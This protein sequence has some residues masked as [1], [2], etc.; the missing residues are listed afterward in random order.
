MPVSERWRTRPFNIGVRLVVKA[1]R[2]LSSACA[3]DSVV[4]IVTTMATNLVRIA[5]TMIMTRLLM[6]EV[7]GLAGIINTIFFVVTM[8]TDLGFQAYIVRHPEGEG[9]HFLRVIWTIH[10]VRGGALAVVGAALAVPASHLL[11]KTELAL[12]LAIA[13]TIFLINGLASLSLITAL[14]TFQ[15]RKLCWLDLGVQI[16]QTFV[17]LV[18]A[19]LL[20]SVWSIIIAMIASAVLRTVLSYLLF[21]NSRH[22]IAVDRGISKDFWV[23][24]RFVVGSSLLTLLIVQSDKIILARIFSLHHFGLYVIAATLAAVPVGFVGA[25]A[26]RMLYPRYAGLFREAPEKIK[27][28]YIMLSGVRSRCY[29]ALHAASLLGARR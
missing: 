19:I 2:R 17:A 6:P 16:F 25:Y 22:G 8:L 27:F 21:P 3:Q 13:S 26:S 9:R 20:R 14:R 18:F 23:F 1:G 4:L 15:I 11:A 29:M 10:A 24:S 12:P 5:S 28:V 7:F